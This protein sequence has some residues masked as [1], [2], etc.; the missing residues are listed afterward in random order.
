MSDWLII[1]HVAYEGPGAI[2]EALARAGHQAHIVRA[3]LGQAVPPTS[4]LDDVGGLVVMGG[5]MGVHDIDMFDWLIP[6]REL[7]QAAVTDGCAV[8]GVC[9]G[10]QQLAAALGAE[11]MTGNGEEIGPG[12]VVLT[13]DGRRDPVLHPAGFEVPCMHWHGDTFDLP[14]RRRP[15]GLKRRLPSSGLS[16]GR[17]RPTGCSSMLS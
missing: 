3:D 17:S 11:V 15:P 9:L 7:L 2:T 8:L 5:P 12:Q 10:A 6:E 4:A 13:A 16:G 14:D 1:Q